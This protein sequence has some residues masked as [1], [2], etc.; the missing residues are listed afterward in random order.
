MIGIYEKRAQKV[1]Q[2][3]SGRREGPHGQ[4]QSAEFREPGISGDQS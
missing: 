3:V 4:E 2:S 1:R